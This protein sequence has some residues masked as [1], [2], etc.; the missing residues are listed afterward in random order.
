MPPAARM[1]RLPPLRRSGRTP[2]CEFLPT[3]YCGT[4][5]KDRQPAGASIAFP[6]LPAA[7]ARLPTMVRGEANKPAI[8]RR[9]DKSVISE[10]F[11][12]LEKEPLQ[13]LPCQEAE[14]IGRE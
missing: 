14:Q 6:A 1:I 8:D 2:S 3:R 4:F 10:K 13:I 7:P 9:K 5:P 11:E 12:K